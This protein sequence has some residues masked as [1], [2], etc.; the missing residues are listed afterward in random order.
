MADR[1]GTDE[2]GKGDYFGPL[3]VAAVYVRS[4]DARR[5]RKLGVRDSKRLKDHTVLDLEDRI[6]DGFSHDVVK[7]NPGRYN[8]LHAK[9][10]N[11]NVLL[12]WA[13]ARAIE[14]LLQRVKCRLVVSDQ[15]GDERYLRQ[16]LMDEGRRV[17]LVQ[18]PKAESD[19]AVAAASVLARAA[20][21]RAL[22]GMRRRYGV[23][24]PKGATHVVEAGLAYADLYGIDRLDEVAKTH[25][26]TT[27]VIRERVGRH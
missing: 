18:K 2:S 23:V 7:I 15:F 27:D 13:H 26:K 21:L 19:A 24:F 5:L 8:E 17:E 1:I 6:K 20:Y 25:F 9:L 16:S 14:N 4:G 10:G 12:A 22:S 11:L 3:T